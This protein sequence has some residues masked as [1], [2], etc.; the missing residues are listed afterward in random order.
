METIKEDGFLKTVAPPTL[1]FA[2]N[3]GDIQLTSNPEYHRKTKHIPIKYHKSRE[4]VK[5]ESILFEWVPTQ[6]MLADGLTKL[7]GATKFLDF[8]QMIGMVDT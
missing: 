8:V 2:E 5:D 1:I 7:L 6:E 4:L 3:Q